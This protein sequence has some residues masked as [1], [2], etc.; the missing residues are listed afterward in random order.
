MG[1]R[2]FSHRKNTRELFSK[3]SRGTFDLEESDDLGAEFLA[4]GQ[5]VAIPLMLGGAKQVFAS[6]QYDKQEIFNPFVDQVVNN[7]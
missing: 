3:S 6:L 4:D 1:F 7:I 5:V 2:L